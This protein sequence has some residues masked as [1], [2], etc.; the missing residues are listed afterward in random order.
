MP[1]RGSR[2]MAWLV[3]AKEPAKSIGSTGISA[4]MPDGAATRLALSK[5]TM[6]KVL[7][8]GKDF[9]NSCST[10]KGNRVG[11]QSKGLSA[12]PPWAK[13]TAMAS[14]ATASAASRPPKMISAFASL[15]GSRPSTLQVRSRQPTLSHGMQS[16]ERSFTPCLDAAKLRPMSSA[17]RVSNSTTPMGATARKSTRA[18]ATPNVSLYV[19]SRRDRPLK[20]DASASSRKRAFMA[21]MLQNAMLTAKD[22][23]L[24]RR[25]AIPGGSG[26]GRSARKNTNRA[27]PAPSVEAPAPTSW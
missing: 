27:A 16:P 8:S 11:L 21:M 24:A 2:P 4:S 9:P 23:P 14:T 7:S 13:P 25:L 26:I 20:K 19:S 10:A 3:S 12:R 6:S 18:S 17:S 22:A 1:P 5:P 15:E